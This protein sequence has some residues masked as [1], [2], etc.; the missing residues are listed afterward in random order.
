MTAKIEDIQFID[1]G[2]NQRYAIIR[3][4]GKSGKRI[5]KMLYNSLPYVKDWLQVHPTHLAIDKP[6]YYAEM[7]RK[8]EDEN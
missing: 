4:V 7:V 2:Y 8:T 5:K 3:V 6:I 1:E